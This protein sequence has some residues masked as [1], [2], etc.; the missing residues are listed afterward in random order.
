MVIDKEQGKSLAAKK[1][2]MDEKMVRKYLK[3][4]KL[5]SQLKK[6]RHYRPRKDPFASVWEECHPLLEQNAGP[7]AKQLFPHLQRKCPGRFSDD[8]LRSFQRKV[9]TWLTLYSFYLQNIPHQKI[10]QKFS[11][12]K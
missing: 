6:P 12:M 1:C 5:P 2:S 11:S 7:E 9:K 8:Q 10:I 3:E 4:G